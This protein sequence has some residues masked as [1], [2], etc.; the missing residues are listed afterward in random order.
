MKATEHSDVEQ[1]TVLCHLE[2]K[3]L[4]IKVHTKS[5]QNW[6]TAPRKFPLCESLLKENEF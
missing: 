6:R 2:D 4:C 3:V 5:V 1:N